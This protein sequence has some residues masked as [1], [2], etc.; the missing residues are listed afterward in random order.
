MRIKNVKIK[1]LYYFL[2]W[3]ILFVFSIQMHA[4]LP[5]EEEAKNFAVSFWNES[6][7]TK[8]H[9]MVN[10]H[11]LHSAS[12]GYLYVPDGEKGFVWVSGCAGKPILL[13]YGHE[14]F[15]SSSDVP[16]MLLAWMN[17]QPLSAYPST[18]NVHEVVKPLL[19]SEWTQDSPFNDL[20]PY[21][22]YDDGS[23]SDVRC[24]VGCVATATSEIMRYYA[25]PKVLCDTLHGWTT[26]HYVIDNVMPGTK[27]DWENILDSY[28]GDYTSSEAKAVAELSLYAGMACHMDYGVEASGSQI[29]YL[30][31]P[32]RHIFGY[33]YVNFYDRARFSPEAWNQVLQFELQRGI[34]LVYSAFSFVFSGHAFV[35]DGIDEKGFYHVRW[36]N[37]SNYNGYFDIDVLS[38]LEN[39]DDPTETGQL[40]GYFCN[41]AALALHP[42]IQSL[43][44]GD[45]L[46]YKPEDITVN[47]VVFLRNP[48]LEGY[49][50]VDVTLTNHSNDTITYTFVAFTT[51][52]GD[53]ID[54]S[55]TNTVGATAVTLFPDS[56]QS[57]RV[58]CNFTNTEHT[59]LGLSG[60]GDHVLCQ[61]PFHLEKTNGHQLDFSETTLLNLDAQSACFQLSVTN[62]S[63]ENW[64]GDM[65][66]YCLVEKG[67]PL[68]TRHW[69]ILNL[70]PGE[71][72]SDTISFSG[73][74]P[75]QDYT[76]NAHCPWTT[77]STYSFHTPSTVSVRDAE[78][79]SDQ[80]IWQ[81][82]S[83]QGLY[84]GKVGSEQLRQFLSLLPKGCY[85]VTSL[86]GCIK[87]I[88]NR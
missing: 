19:Q 65:V 63:S 57:A 38:A 78:V 16:D 60:D 15:V 30:T 81:I 87:R 33:E 23:I 62:L 5:D 24:Q 54:W 47:N 9:D 52:E 12:N 26:T 20:C 25:Y 75:D 76:F 88:Y 34:P 14:T 73:L 17:I 7:V 85:V 55:Q 69:T 39:P 51:V 36:G 68:D 29:F 48:D 44:E 74:K 84:L 67:N 61:I 42:D 3:C 40:N 77:V 1:P 2:S 43:F 71:T 21:Y 31:E 22:R 32:L 41:Q 45:T 49:V 56:T 50:P 35:I 72:L 70:S 66:T 59:V 4:Q 46:T 58:Y 6:G 82:Y 28:S 8:R 80:I 11:L 27:I 37:G 13:G 10:M 18:K 83:L 64:A 79:D 53:S 86:D